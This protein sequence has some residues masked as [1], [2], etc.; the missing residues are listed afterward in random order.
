MARLAV[1]PYHTDSEAV[2]NSTA[3]DF[4]AQI[5]A[6]MD[7][8][9]ELQAKSDAL[10]SGEVLGALLSFPVADGYAH[11]LVVKERPLT[12]QHVPYVDAYQLPAAHVRG[13]NKTEVLMKLEQRRKWAKI[14]GRR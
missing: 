4:A 11:Y 9:G 2:D 7:V 6:E 5:K 10:V 3:R 12:L 8:L 13:I 14:T 1:K